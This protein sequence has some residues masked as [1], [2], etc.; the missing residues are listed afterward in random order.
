MW[1][2]LQDILLSY[3]SKLERLNTL[4]PSSQL[5]KDVGPPSANFVNNQLQTLADDQ[6]KVTVQV[7]APPVKDNPE[8]ETVDL[9]EEMEEAM[10]QNLPARCV[11]NMG[12]PQLSA[13]TDMMK[14]LWETI[15]LL[16]DTTQEKEAT[17]PLL[18]HQ[19]SSTMKVG[20]L[21]VEQETIKPKMLKPLPTRLGTMVWKN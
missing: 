7:V 15:Q 14:H 11:E 12:I 6:T 3:D 21:T 17:L 10:A 18:Q 5:L 2:E 20:T 13:T 4:T 8:E 19:K 1:Q 9:V 16:L